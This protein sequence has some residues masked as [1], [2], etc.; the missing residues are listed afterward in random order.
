MAVECPYCEYEGRVDAVEAHISGKSDDAHRGRVGADLR[1]HLPQ[2]EE[3]ESI[4]VGTALI[5]ATA[6]YVVGAWV[7]AH[8]GSLD[9][10]QQEV[11]V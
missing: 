10:D 7:S 3:S 4:D 6:L 1:E 2:V 9:L 8:G 5:L 11:P